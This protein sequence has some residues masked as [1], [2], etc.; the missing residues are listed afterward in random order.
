MIA[1]FVVVGEGLSEGDGL[2]RGPF[3]LSRSLAQVLS[4]E[5][6]AVQHPSRDLCVLICE[7]R[8][9]RDSV[10]WVIICSSLGHHRPPVGFYC[11]ARQ[12]AKGRRGYVVY[13]Y[14]RPLHLLRWPGHANY[15]GV[16]SCRSLL[17]QVRH[18]ANFQ[19]CPQCFNTESLAAA[20]M[21]QQQQANGTQ[22]HPDP[23]KLTQTDH[24]NKRLL[25]AF[26]SAMDN[27]NLP[28]NP[29]IQ[30][31]DEEEAAGDR[32]GTEDSMDTVGH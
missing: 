8:G 3:P 26:Q 23:S 29:Q 31:G 28:A 10:R 1:K 20:S 12:C 25:M 5:E 4:A 14:G 30:T 32:N 9:K 11:F 2:R 18:G 24:L 17:G 7:S 19:C 6:K 16:C 27:M 21:E 13:L 15:L 22:V